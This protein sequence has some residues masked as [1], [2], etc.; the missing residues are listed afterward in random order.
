[1]GLG[2][3]LKGMLTK[4]IPRPGGDVG[5][6]PARG[7]VVEVVSAPIDNSDILNPDV[8]LWSKVV[9]SLRRA[10]AP[11]DPGTRVDT[12]L[13]TRAWREIDAGH[14]VPVRVDPA[15]GRLLGFDAEAYEGEVDARR[16]A[17]KRSPT[18]SDPTAPFPSIDADEL[19]PIE[20]VS[21][22]QWATTYARMMK[23]GIVMPADQDAFAASRGAPPGR[24]AAI[25]G[26]WQARSNADWKISSKFA[27]AYAAEI[28]RKT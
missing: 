21:L 18:G 25:M 11:D 22:E 19:E 12:W 17:A 2:K 14:E 28:D 15:S 23:D 24:W 3:K 27:T 4:A 13:Q 1:M 10:D 8:A 9:L 6:V 26:E 7:I 16:E 5:G 20:G